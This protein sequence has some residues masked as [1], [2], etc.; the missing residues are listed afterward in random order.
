MK[1][2]LIELPTDWS[3]QPRPVC[4]DVQWLESPKPPMPENLPITARRVEHPRYRGVHSQ[5]LKGDLP[6][7][8]IIGT[9]VLARKRSVAGA[10]YHRPGVPCCAAAVDRHL[11]CKSNRVCA[12]VRQCH[13][14]Y[15]GASHRRRRSLA[16][17]FFESVTAGGLVSA[18][19]PAL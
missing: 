8:Q 1:T 6:H 16:P 10:V 4:P 9:S 18:L 2:H 5:L 19:E 12:V 3:P 11:V 7:A 15:R 14:V 13:A 17:T